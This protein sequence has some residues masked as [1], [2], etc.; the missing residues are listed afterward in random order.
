MYYLRLRRFPFVAL[1]LIGFLLPLPEPYATVAGFAAWAS[2]TVMLVEH[3]IILAVS[4][5]YGGWYQG[6]AVAGWAIVVAGTTLPEFHRKSKELLRLLEEDWQREQVMAAQQ[7]RFAEAAKQAALAEREVRSRRYIKRLRRLLGGDTPEL[8]QTSLVLTT[9]H[10]VEAEARLQRAERMSVLLGEASQLGQEH[11][12]YLTRLFDQ[13]LSQAEEER[14]AQAYLGQV[15]RLN[16]MLKEAHQLQVADEVAGRLQRGDEA[17]AGAVLTRARASAA[18][19]L[20]LQQL[21][22]EVVRAPAHSRGHLTDLLANVRVNLGNPR[23]FRKAVY[24]LRQSL[25]KNGHANPRT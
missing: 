14:Q 21:K 19:H 9:F 12:D 22:S 20:E 11:V 17:A 13:R 24:T 7:A 23:E 1:V 8:E 10:P 6:F 15:C 2:S 16:A 4:V 25:P 18:R 5:H 3:L